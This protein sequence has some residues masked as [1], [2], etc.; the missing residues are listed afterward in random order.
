MKKPGFNEQVYFE[1]LMKAE[2]N[3]IPNLFFKNK[4]GFVFS[5]E[6]KSANLE[7][8]TFS[9]GAAY[10]DLDNDGDLDVVV[11]NLD[12]KAFVIENLINTEAQNHYLTN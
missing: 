5:N 2:Q 9:N 11:N 8:P 3:P 10:G 1:Q 4:D 7:N 6:T 12:M